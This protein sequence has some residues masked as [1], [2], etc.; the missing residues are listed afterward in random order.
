MTMIYFS[1]ERLDWRDPYNWNTAPIV[2]RGYDAAG[3]LLSTLRSDIFTEVVST[4]GVGYDLAAYTKNGTAV[5]VR[6][7][8][9]NGYNPC[10][11]GALAAADDGRLYWASGPFWAYVDGTTWTG[12][13]VI[14]FFRVYN[15]NGDRVPF[16][17][18]HGSLIRA[19]KLDSSG[20]IIVGGESNGTLFYTLRKY[21]SV[22]S[23]I[24][25]AATGNI[26]VDIA[27]D[28]SDNIYAAS[29]NAIVKYNSAGTLQWS[30]SLVYGDSVYTLAV[31]ATYL[32]DSGFFNGGR[33]EKR[34][35]SDGEIVTSV[36]TDYPNRI[37]ISG[38]VIYS[39]EWDSYSSTCYKTFDTD[40][41]L[42]TTINYET[43]NGGAFVGSYCFLGKPGV[44]VN[45]NIYFCGNRRLIESTGNYHNLFHFYSLT[46][47]HAKRW[48]NL[49][50]TMLPGISYYTGTIRT[51]T[52]YGDYDYTT[53][54][55]GDAGPDLGINVIGGNWEF[56]RNCSVVTVVENTKLPGLDIRLNY[57]IPIWA[58][59][60]YIDVPGLPISLAFGALQI[61]RDYVG[62][63]KY[64][65][66]YRLYLT[67]S[68]N[69]ELPIS[70]L[71]C[72]SDLYSL[73]LYLVVPWLTSDLI[74]AIEARLTGELVLFKGIR[75]PNGTEQIDEMLRVP[76]GSLRYDMGPQSSSASISGT[77]ANSGGGRTRTLNGI[78]YR[79]TIGTTRRVRCAVDTY[80]QPGDTANLGND[81]T[82]IVAEIVYNIG[83]D[84][85]TMEIVE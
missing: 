42:L 35:L 30:Q 31:D 17:Q 52:G 74:A 59:D 67:G 8:P 24:W 85:S 21:D 27:I 53:A 46:S 84:Q 36:N 29:T 49:A 10:Y 56:W 82:L 2:V 58:G 38:S 50:A 34:N 16:P 14:D 68:P 32:Y 18:L 9:V 81:E 73:T 37:S 83:T 55:G 4:S 26:V 78:N 13:L 20:N 72:R 6:H 25:S 40:L 60:R 41:N 48:D 61:W 69:I 76:F 23:L 57:G 11:P 65:E 77:I 75:F 19:V 5:T 64:P 15:R 39:V 12:D 1:G 66:I 22:G 7:N 28:S 62:A 44:D 43:T 47:A 71:Q 45:G 33:I 63:R 54:Y 3:N 79:N 80:L 51:D 70:S